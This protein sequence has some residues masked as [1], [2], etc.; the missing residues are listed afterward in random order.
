MAALAVTLAVILFVLGLVGTILPI[1]P[2]VILIYAGMLV[3]GLLTGFTNLDTAFFIMQGM[4]V[5]LVFSLDYLAAAAGSR[6][7]GGGRSAAWGAA[8]GIL[9]GF[10]F[11]GPFGLIIGPFLGAVLAELITGRQPAEA[12]RAGFGSLVGFVGGTLLKLA[13]EVMMIVWF[14]MSIR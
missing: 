11:F 9:L 13:I 1:M 2:G 8:L 3:Y 5:V 12:V 7:Y 10:I 4:A 14:F 6:R